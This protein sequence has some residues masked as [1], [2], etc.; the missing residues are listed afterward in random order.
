VQLDAVPVRVAEPRLPAVVRAEER[1]GHLDRPGTELGDGCGHVVDLQA[2]VLEGLPLGRLAELPLEELDEAS[3]AHVEVDPEALPLLVD[4]VEGVPQAQLP[5]VEGFGGI[6]IANGE[7]DMREGLDQ[8][9]PPLSSVT[10]VEPFPGG[11][12]ATSRRGLEAGDGEASP[13]R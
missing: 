7:A 2:E 12:S 1:V 9:R 6:E 8:V 4:E 3:V 5:G 11:R 13:S 10:A